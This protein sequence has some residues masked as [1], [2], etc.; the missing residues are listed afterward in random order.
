MIEQLAAALACLLPQE[1]RDELRERKAPAAEVIRC[2]ERHHI[3][4][5]AFGGADKWWNLHPMLKAEHRERSRGDT[6]IAF[7]A[8]RLDERWGAFMRAI[9]AGRKP[10][11][12]PKW[13]WPA[14][15]MANRR[16][17]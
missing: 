8:K 9:D 14:R 7:K 2:F 16:R 3:T 6:S 4:L 5:H 10:R 1:R 17:P 13:K 12:A 15:K 11:P